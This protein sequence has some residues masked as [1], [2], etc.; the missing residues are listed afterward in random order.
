MNALGY[1]H[2]IEGENLTTTLLLVHKLHCTNEKEQLK[3]KMHPTRS[4]KAEVATAT[5]A[6][7]PSTTKARETTTTKEGTE[8]ITGIKV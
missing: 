4:C 8:Q 7:T 1:V 2:T 6:V 3:L 5:P